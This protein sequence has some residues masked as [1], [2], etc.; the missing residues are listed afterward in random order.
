M[1]RIG[2]RGNS[3][4]SALWFESS[5][6][7][8]IIYREKAYPVSVTLDSTVLVVLEFRMGYSFFLELLVFFFN[9]VFSKFT[10]NLVAII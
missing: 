2:S 10:F 7:S 4:I 5:L 1:I 6:G 9:I 8:S 3:F